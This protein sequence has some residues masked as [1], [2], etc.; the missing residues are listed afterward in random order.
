MK[1]KETQQ[2]SRGR[3][4]QDRGRG[5]SARGTAVSNPRTPENVSSSTSSSSTFVSN[6]NNNDNNNVGPDQQIASPIL[7]EEYAQCP[8]T[9]LEELYAY[10]QTGE[11]PEDRH[12]VLN[13][14]G[15]LPL[16]GHPKVITYQN[17]T[18]RLFNLNAVKLIKPILPRLRC[19]IF[20]NCYV[21]S[22]ALLFLYSTIANSTDS[23]PLEEIFFQQCDL[24]EES[25]SKLRNTLLPALIE[26]TSLKK[27]T[28]DNNELQVTLDSLIQQKRGEIQKQEEDSEKKKHEQQKEQ[29]E[30]KKRL[31]EQAKERDQRYNDLQKALEQHQTLHAQLQRDME[32]LKG[33]MQQQKTQ[34]FEGEEAKKKMQQLEEEKKTLENKLKEQEEITR[35][36]E[37]ELAQLRSENEKLKLQ[38]EEAKIAS[39]SMMESTNHQTNELL[40]ELEEVDKKG[41]EAIDRKTN[42]ES[43]DNNETTSS[44]CLKELQDLYDCSESSATL[45]RIRK[46]IWK[47]G[48]AKLL[49][50]EDD[51]VKNSHFRTSEVVKISF[52]D[53][54]ISLDLTGVLREENFP[55]NVIDKSGKQIKLYN[56][57]ALELIKPLLPFVDYIIFDNCEISRD[58]LV[59]LQSFFVFSELNEHFP[60][61]GL[62]FRNCSFSDPSKAFLLDMIPSLVSN[63]KIEIIGVCDEDDENYREFQEQ[64]QK[65]IEESKKAEESR[66]DKMQFKQEQ[67]EHARRMQQQAEE[68]YRQS[69]EKH[70]AEL[71]E[72]I[73]SLKEQLEQKQVEESKKQALLSKFSELSAEIKRQTQQSSQPQNLPQLMQLEQQLKKLGEKVDTSVKQLSGQQQGSEQTKEQFNELIENL[74]SE[75][76]ALSSQVLKS[77]QKN[78]SQHTEQKQ[79][80][81][82]DRKAE[83]HKEIQL[84]QEQLQQQQKQQT[85]EEQ[86]RFTQLEQRLKSLGEKID[87]SVQKPGEQ[88]QSANQAE[89]GMKQLFGAL[90]DEIKQLA[91]TIE[92]NAKQNAKQFEEQKKKLEQERQA[93]SVQVHHQEKSLIKKE[94]AEEDEET[95][96]FYQSL[97]QEEEEEREEVEEKYNDQ[98]EMGLLQKLEQQS[99]TES[100][101]SKTNIQSEQEIEEMDSSKQEQVTASK[102]VMIQSSEQ[103]LKTLAEKILLKISKVYAAMQ[104]F[105]GT[106]EEKKK[107]CGQKIQEGIVDIIEEHLDEDGGNL[108]D[109][110][111][112]PE[113]TVVV[114]KTQQ[115][116]LSPDRLEKGAKQIREDVQAAVKD[117]QKER[118]SKEEDEFKDKEEKEKRVQKSESGSLGAM[119]SQSLFEFDSST[120][121]THVNFTNPFSSTN[122]FADSF[123]FEP[124]STPQ[125]S[126][127]FHPT[128]ILDSIFSADNN[129]NTPSSVQTD[130]SSTQATSSTST[131]EGYTI[132]D[133]YLA[134]KEGRVEPNVKI[135]SDTFDGGSD[136]VRFVFKEQKGG[137]KTVTLTQNQ[138]LSKIAEELHKLSTLDLS[139]NRINDTLLA[140]F[141]DACLKNKSFNR[142]ET[143]TTNFQTLDL[144]GNSFSNTVL[145]SLTRFIDRTKLFKI[146]VD[147]PELQ[148]QVDVEAKDARRNKETTLSENFPIT[149]DQ[150]PDPSE[151]EQSIKHSLKQANQ[152]PSFIRLFSGGDFTDN[153]V[154]VLF[155]TMLRNGH[156]FELVSLLGSPQLT[157][158]SLELIIKFLEQQPIKIRV[159]VDKVDWRDRINNVGPKKPTTRKGK[160]EIV[161]FG[162]SYKITWP[163]VFKPVDDISLPKHITLHYEQLINVPEALVREMCEQIKLCLQNKD[164]ISLDLN[165]AGSSEP[166]KELLQWILDNL[167]TIV[168]ESQ[169][170]QIV[171]RDAA[172]Q[173]KINLAIQG[174][175][176]PL[177]FVHSDN[178][179]PLNFKTLRSDHSLVMLGRP[180]ANGKLW[181]DFYNSIADEKPGKRIRKSVVVQDALKQFHKKTPPDEITLTGTIDSY[182][183]SEGLFKYILPRAISVSL[184]EHKFDDIDIEKL[185]E[186]V[187][188]RKSRLRTLDLGKCQLSEKHLQMLLWTLSVYPS[189]ITQIIINPSHEKYDLYRGLLNKYTDENKRVLDLYT[190]GGTF[191]LNAFDLFDVYQPHQ[192]VLTQTLKPSATSTSSSS[193]TSSTD[194]G[195]DELHIPNDEEW[196]GKKVDIS[197]FFQSVQAAGATSQHNMPLLYVKDTSRV[198][199]S[200]QTETQLHLVA[201]LATFCSAEG[202]KTTTLKLGTGFNYDFLLKFLYFLVSTKSRLEVVDF[203]EAVGQFSKIQQKQ[204]KRELYS[205]VTLYMTYSL[206]YVKLASEKTDSLFEKM[207]NKQLDINHQIL[208]GKAPRVSEDSVVYPCAHIDKEEFPQTRTRRKSIADQLKAVGG[209]IV[210]SKKTPPPSPETSKTPARPPTT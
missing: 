138:A 163:D 124:E 16:Q 62:A 178:Q 95:E 164:I 107:V 134:I 25:A 121:Q 172:L 6:N 3:G 96:V 103:D 123:K 120:P 68:K 47:S 122:P 14:S 149:L 32:L 76:Q 91:S 74:K 155:L 71:Q 20:N 111:S 22:S 181:T 198:Q 70:Q 133:F 55:S 63:T 180:R 109:V 132:K 34:A 50:K 18:V 136:E 146:Y 67:A 88:Q 102:R 85:N 190:K 165:D 139:H 187:R 35:K 26:K 161:D 58:F 72:K 33:Q 30:R 185:L 1:R 169:L 40:S 179:T 31:E 52:E 89:E 205:L 100:L 24:N 125:P 51:L 4:N 192:K 210:G 39:T 12:R 13:L 77:N 145:L 93:F 140:H 175:F 65:K 171:V 144:R 29:Q 150:T 69:V 126:Q 37:E 82:Q 186:L 151:R 135:K 174:E 206:Q 59:L 105:K 119:I 80:L 23:M 113:A 28:V 114:Y 118:K 17:N 191:N 15:Q 78:S 27:V 204:F 208:N 49:S 207:I 159:L 201:T 5:S 42:E 177:A 166:V 104:S 195:S 7:P 75:F 110:E 81:D 158:L 209:A 83:L 116:T 97:P 197:A 86:Q 45:G 183:D 143:T 157:K 189:V 21:D 43:N 8:V 148:L 90:T 142:A 153:D 115:S 60:L 56:P 152:E 154:A 10:S 129:N 117:V 202:Y 130:F 38:Q 147:D 200:H 170:N 173:E 87:A 44:S 176:R 162:T 101:L 203:S 9:T 160:E 41:N 188:C 127:S 36:N 61:E 184:P 108:D 48:K 199:S 19:I 66:V 128:S 11:F 167:P 92:E 98:I 2:A 131:A 141:L 99:E 168:P 112:L 53:K 194:D 137:E 73:N 106:Q 94:D 46:A 193:S 57:T 84:L 54:E 64:I 156:G 79:E 182:A 196:E